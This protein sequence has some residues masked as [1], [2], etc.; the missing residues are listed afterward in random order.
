MS[1]QPTARRVRR[2][3][4]YVQAARTTWRWFCNIVCGLLVIH[5]VSLLLLLTVLEM[6]GLGLMNFALF[7]ALA[8]GI[9]QLRPRA[10]H[11]V[12]PRWYVEALMEIGG[13][14]QV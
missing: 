12:V 10:G 5:G 14:E 3:P 11:N 4:E 1:S 7:G 9:W 13:E 6:L 8:F 2:T